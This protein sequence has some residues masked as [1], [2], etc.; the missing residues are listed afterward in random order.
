MFYP[1]GVF[2]HNFHPFPS[3]GYKCVFYRFLRQLYI[4]D[5]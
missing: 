5:N 3:M 2:T 1:N 4:L